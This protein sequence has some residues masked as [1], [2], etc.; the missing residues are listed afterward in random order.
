MQVLE[1]VMQVLREVARDEVMPRFL[2]V[3]KSRKDDGTLFTEA[4]M[5]CQQALQA[6]LPRILPHPV[7]GEEMELAEQDRLWAENQDGLWVVDPID[8]TTN[9]VNGLPYFAISVGLMVGGKS[10][11]G[12][13][14][15]PVSQE[16]FYASR[17]EGAFLNGQRLPLKTVVNTM[18]D[19]IASVEVKYLRSGKLA[20]RIGSTCPCGSLRNLGSSTL[21]WCYLA[22]GRYDLYLH[23][24]QRLWDYAAGAVILEEAGGQIASLNSDDYWSD[25]IWKRSAIAALNPELF[26][27]WHRWVR[28]NQ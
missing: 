17:G 2:H 23:G 8:G 24:G 16:M 14:Y 20:A 18:C 1:Q 25:V 19:A 11:L 4:D 5:A 10:R 26:S 12:V 6:A 22:A 27:Q 15:N 28:A 3:G 21:D 9:F 7:L 13:I